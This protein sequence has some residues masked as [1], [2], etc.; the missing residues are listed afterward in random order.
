VYGRR[1]EVEFVAK[2]RDEAH[3]STVDEMV[4][5][6]RVDEA[7]ARTILAQTERPE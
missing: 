2:L 1:F 7:E 4:A 6:M 3:F 5:Q